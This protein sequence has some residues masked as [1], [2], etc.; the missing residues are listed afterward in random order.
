[1]N[2]TV[3]PL[4][5]G[6]PHDAPL[7]GHYE[8]H[9][10]PHPPPPEERPHVT[11]FAKLPP[12]APKQENSFGQGRTE[13]FRLR[14]LMPFNPAQAYAMEV[15]PAQIL[16]VQRLFLGLGEAMLTSTIQMQKS[17]VQAMAV[18][19]GVAEKEAQ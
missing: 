4:H 18:Q 15:V 11:P 1:M 9:E 12:A 16:G 14:S 8:S 10:A 17:L 2:R 6:A 3:P 19:M 13:G 7:Q 5:H